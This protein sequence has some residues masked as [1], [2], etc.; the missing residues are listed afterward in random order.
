[1]T[2][3]STRRAALTALGG[4]GAFLLAAC[5]G[6]PAGGTAGQPG[7]APTLRR[8]V[9]LQ[10]MTDAGTP[11]HSEARD[12]QAAAFKE[13]TGVQVERQALPDLQAKL[14]AAFAAGTPPDL[15]FTRVTT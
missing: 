14:Q 5:G 6:A 7:P 2:E 15:Y 8:G 4:G 9:T 12:K 13:A 10:W 3:R 1:M 11:A